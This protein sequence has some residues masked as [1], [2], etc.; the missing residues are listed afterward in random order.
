MF[1]DV[2][3]ARHQTWGGVSRESVCQQEFV[4]KLYGGRW[5]SLPSARIPMQYDERV[6]RF[7]E[8]GAQ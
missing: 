2:S 5:V 4:N 8:C 6:Y 7:S 1:S 3:Y